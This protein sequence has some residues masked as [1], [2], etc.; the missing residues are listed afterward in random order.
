MNTFPSVILDRKSLQ[1]CKDALELE[2]DTKNHK[3]DRNTH[4]II[5]V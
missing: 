1:G 3:A 4:K 5:A 2:T